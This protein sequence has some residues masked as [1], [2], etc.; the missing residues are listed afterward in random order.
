MLTGDKKETAVNLAHSAGILRQT[1]RLLDL[2]DTADPRDAATLLEEAA[3][4]AAGGDEQQQSLVIDGKSLTALFRSPVSVKQ[5]QR[6]SMRCETVVACRLS[7]IQKSQLVR[8]VKG[9]IVEWSG[10]SKVR[11]QLAR[12]GKGEIAAG[13]AGQ[14]GQKWGCQLARMVMG[15]I[16]R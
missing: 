15:E 8:L 9:E 14:I 10:W 4:A 6:L 11:S 2:C 7:P 12:L 5:L 1:S 3:T 13:Q 16:F